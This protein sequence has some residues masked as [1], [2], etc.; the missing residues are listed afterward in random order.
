MCCC[1]RRG[2]G[3]AIVLTDP[4]LIDSC[5]DGRGLIR[6]TGL[7]EATGECSGERNSGGTG[8]C[9]GVTSGDICPIW[10]I[11]RSWGRDGWYIWEANCGGR[12]DGEK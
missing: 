12:G 9:I 2:E 6:R 1:E 3:G 7:G 11:C 8:G 4:G 10:N 5:G